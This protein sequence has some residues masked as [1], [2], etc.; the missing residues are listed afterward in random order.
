L[1][2]YNNYILLRHDSDETV[3]EKH[4]ISVEDLSKSIVKMKTKLLAVREKRIRPGLDDK[5]LTS[6]NALMLKAYVDAYNV[7]EEKRFLDAAIKNATFILQ[8]QLRHDDGLNHNYKNG[9][10]TINGYLEDYCYTIEALIALYEATFVE[11][12]LLKADELMQYC[13]AHFQDKKSGMFYFTSD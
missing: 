1:W 13:I 11:R 2:E 3:A 12:Y 8:K 4:N 9:R 6:W 7:F 10:S 5:T